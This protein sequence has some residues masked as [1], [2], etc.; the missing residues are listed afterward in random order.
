MREGWGEEITGVSPSI[1]PRA[2]NGGRGGVSLKTLLTIDSELNYVPNLANP[3]RSW[4]MA[5]SMYST[6]AK[7]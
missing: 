3:G 7:G 4:R 5:R 2:N 6:C 1:S